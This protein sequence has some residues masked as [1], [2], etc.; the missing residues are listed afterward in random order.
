MQHSGE[1]MHCLLN[2]H[3]QKS[4]LAMAQH[5]S[6]WVWYLFFPLFSIEVKRKPSL[7]SDLFV[8]FPECM[9][10]FQCEADSII[11]NSCL[12]SLAFFFPEQISG[13][14]IRHNTR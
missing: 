14:L 2:E 12:E 10:C 11:I 5:S 4:F 1:V 6:Q 3:P 8:F 9:A 7:L 13:Y